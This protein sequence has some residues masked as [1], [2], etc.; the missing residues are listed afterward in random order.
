MFTEIKKDIGTIKVGSNNK[1]IFNFKNILL[2]KI[3]SSCDC[4]TV[5]CNQVEGILTVTYIPKPFPVHIKKTGQKIIHTEKFVY[6][7]YMG[8]DG[9]SVG[10]TTLSFEAKIV[11]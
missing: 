9:K 6:V 1:I 3:Q 2:T 8:T 7:D 4:T 11:E 5:D 10:S